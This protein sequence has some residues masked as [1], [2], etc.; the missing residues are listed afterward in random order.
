MERIVPADWMP[1]AS[2]VRVIVHWTAGAP[3]ASSLDKEHYHVLV[4]QDLEL[5]RGVFTIKD[6]DNTGDDRYA[7]H[8]KG[9][10]TRSIGISLCGMSGSSEHPFIPGP[11]PIKEPQWDRAAR[12][13]AELCERY[14]IPVTPQT[15]LQHGEVQEILGA[16][17]NGKWDVCRL[18]WKPNWSHAQVGEDFRTRVKDHLADLV[19]DENPI[20]IKATVLGIEAPG[21]L[22]DSQ[23][24]VAIRPLEDGGI[25]TI[26]RVSRDGALLKVGNREVA[27]AYYNIG[28]KGF[29]PARKLAEHL[30]AELEWNSAQ[31]KLT[32]RK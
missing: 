7:A 3:N 8:T 14:D 11:H 4:E 21:F 20:P 25:F 22:E 10:N 13:V 9:K 1:D 5:V 27:L 30:G 2:P 19:E 15:V 24:L 32:I 18:P 23:A 26:K 31:R 16:P 28:G 29:V 12:V 6:N 17:Q